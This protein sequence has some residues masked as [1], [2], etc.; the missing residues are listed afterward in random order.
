MKYALA[1]L[2]LL[3]LAVLASA[4]DFN[5]RIS[6]KEA[7]RYAEKNRELFASLAIPQGAK[8]V[9]ERD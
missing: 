9:R 6:E 7:A 2:L 4:C 5:A 3:G 1:I 8:L